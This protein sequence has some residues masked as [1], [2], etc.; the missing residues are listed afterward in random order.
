MLFT[1]L[2]YI[3]KIAESQRELLQAREMIDE[4]QRSLSSSLEDQS[5]GDVPSG[6]IDEDSERL[7]SVKAA[8]VSSVVGVLAS[9]PISFYEAHDFPQLFVQLSVIFISCALFGVTFRYAIRR[10]LDNVQLKTG[11][12]AAF[13]FVR[14][15]AMVESGRPFELSTDAL[16]SLALDGAVSVV[17]NILTFLPAAI[18]LDYCF[19]MRFL[20]PFP[21]RKQ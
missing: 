21:T 2:H 12:A 15:L 11:A 14:G 16:I 3:N 20:S 10:D 13:A 4:A 8:A 7:E 6:D 18:A 9:L 19:K 17:E 5:F 1:M